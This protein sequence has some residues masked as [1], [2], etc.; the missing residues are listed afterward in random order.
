MS[1]IRSLRSVRPESRRFLI[2]VIRELLT[3]LC[4]NGVEEIGRLGFEKSEECVVAL[5]EDG[6]LRC[7]FDRCPA[8][9]PALYFEG[10]NPFTAKFQRINFYY[11]VEALA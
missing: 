9:V 4:K 11:R 10:F 7:V 8:G 6:L 5:I 1:V 3:H 2:T